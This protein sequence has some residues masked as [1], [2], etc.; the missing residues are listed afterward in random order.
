MLKRAYCKTTTF[1]ASFLNRIV[2]PWNTICR[3]V[4]S[5]KFC[6]LSIFKNYL[7]ATY[8]SFLDITFDIDMTCPA[9]GSS[10]A[11]ARATVHNLLFNYCL[12]RI[13]IRFHRLTITF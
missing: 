3:Q 7:R 10:L 8:F 1:Q 9:H 12:L 13:F 5:D 2:K 11:I 6:S 4:T